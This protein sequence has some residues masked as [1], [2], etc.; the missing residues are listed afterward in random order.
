M[1]WSEFTRDSASATIG[2]CELI[3]DGHPVVMLGGAVVAERRGGEAPAEP[4][5]PALG[6][7]GDRLREALFGEERVGRRRA[8]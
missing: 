5:E 2:C 4:R 7:A 8:R 6:L 1:G 3:D